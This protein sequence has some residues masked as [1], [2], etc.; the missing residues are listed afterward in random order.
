M[1]IYKGKRVLGNKQEN[2]EI[3]DFVGLFIILADCVESI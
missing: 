1:S 2:P 3:T